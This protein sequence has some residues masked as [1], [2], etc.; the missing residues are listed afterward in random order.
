MTENGGP[1]AGATG[2]RR[3][4]RVIIGLR[5]ADNQERAIVGIP[6]D[7]RLHHRQKIGPPEA[8]PPLGDEPHPSIGV[9]LAGPPFQ[10]APREVGVR[11]VNI[12]IQR[13]RANRDGR[14]K[15]EQPEPSNPQTARPRVAQMAPGENSNSA[16]HHPA[17]MRIPPWPVNAKGT[18]PVRVARSWINAI[19]MFNT[20]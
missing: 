14:Q 12:V 16:S 3:R 13:R 5:I 9:A 4:G 8:L 1:G 19:P 2:G 18:P 7:R 6:P 17:N 20:C 15:R 10:N 11:R